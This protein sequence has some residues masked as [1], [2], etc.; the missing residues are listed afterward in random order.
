MWLRRNK[1]NLSSSGAFAGE[2]P[3]TSFPGRLPG[4]VFR[5]VKIGL[6]QA[7]SELHHRCSL[8]NTG[9][10]FSSSWPT[11]SSG[12]TTRE[13]LL[14]QNCSANQYSHKESSKQGIGKNVHHGECYFTRWISW[15]SPF[16]SHSQWWWK[17]TQRV[18][19]VPLL[20]H[21][22]RTN[23]SNNL[24]SVM[25]I[26][27]TTSRRSKWAWFRIRLPFDFELWYKHSNFCG[28]YGT[29]SND[30][31]WL[32]CF[33]RKKEGREPHAQAEKAKKLHGLK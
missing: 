22:R 17:E 23:I 31:E 28:N 20:F 9:R 4:L 33:R 6:H 7:P 13:T 19:G 14:T 27:W 21:S 32:H 5:Y 8:W 10:S 3:C 30:C 15:Y 24:E 18:Y 25:A 2:W 26:A 29:R 1:K 11:I 16:G 12:S